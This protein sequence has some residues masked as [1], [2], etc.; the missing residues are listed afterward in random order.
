LSPDEIH[1]EDDEL[2]LDPHV[3]EMYKVALFPDL[4]FSQSDGDI[5]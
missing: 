1:A 2:W 5:E 3:I 4:I